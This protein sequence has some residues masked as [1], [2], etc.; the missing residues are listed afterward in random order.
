MGVEQ[1]DRTA[2]RRRLVRTAAVLAVVVGLGLGSGAA[3]AAVGGFPRQRPVAGPTPCFKCEKVPGS[4]AGSSGAGANAAA[5][6]AREEPAIVD[7]SATLADGSG[8]SDGTGMILTANGEILTNNHVI[9]GSN[10]ISVKVSNGVQ[11]F[12]AQLVGTDAN[13]DVAVLQAQGAVGLSTISLGN[14]S[15]VAVGDGVVAIGNAFARVGPPTVTAGAVTALNQSITVQGDLGETEQLTGVI[16]TNANIE[17]GNSGGPLFNAAGQVI[18]MNTAAANGESPGADTNQSFSIPINHALS[19]KNA[20][21]GG[22]GGGDVSVGQEGFLGVSV[23]TGTRHSSATNGGA[24]VLV[25][26]VAPGSPAATAGIIGGDRITAINGQPLTSATRL[27]QLIAAQHP[28]GVLRV[29]WT[30]PTGQSHTAT[31][32]LTAPPSAP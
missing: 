19:I 32:Q 5:I 24:G 22:R 7:V 11:T 29:T 2:G 14:S 30:D 18:G 21:V 20:I 27:S 12:A 23:Q 3:D 6:G 26:G 17:P 28:G 1:Q 10:Q 9:Q 16:Q 4:P 31:V 25:T 13:D 8:E 15:Q